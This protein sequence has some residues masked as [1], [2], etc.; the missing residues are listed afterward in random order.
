MAQIPY[1]DLSTVKAFLNIA[2]N[3]TSQNVFL[4]SIVPMVQQFIDKY[5]G[6]SFGWGDDDKN[7]G[8]LDNPLIDYSNS[9][10]IAITAVPTL[11]GTSLTVTLSA[12]APWVIGNNVSLYGSAE[13]IYNGVYAITAKPNPVTIVLDVSAQTGT[14]S[15]AAQA[16]VTSGDGYIG[17]YVQ[18]YKYIQQEQYDGSAG[19]EIW[20]QNMDIRSIESVYLGLRNVATPALLPPT[21]YLWRDDGRFFVGGSYFNAYD[22]Q[23]Y[24]NNDSFYGSL[25]NGFQTMTIS[26]YCGYVGVP[27]DISLAAID[28]VV[29]YAMLRKGMGLNYERVGDYQVGYDMMFRKLLQTQPDSL[30]TLNIYRRRKV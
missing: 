19:R 15:G 7:G 18:N 12:P 3:D 5:T 8:L 16:M 11:S 23:M 20:L 14:L 27:S 22:S 1:T 25:V 29:A 13:T 10:G 21:D 6:R 24:S 26:Y 2:P 9:D 4:V 17:N 28:L 30:N